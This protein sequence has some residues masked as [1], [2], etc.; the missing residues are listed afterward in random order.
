MDREVR[1]RVAESEAAALRAPEVSDR[2][3]HQLVS[4][5]KSV[6]STLAAKTSED[7]QQRLALIQ[8]AEDAGPGPQSGDLRKRA[9]SLYQDFLKWRTGALRF[10]AGVEERLAEASW[11]RRLTGSYV[12]TA[13]L[14]ERNR[15]LERVNVLTAAIKAHRDG[16]SDVD[17]DDIDEGDQALWA[18]L[19]G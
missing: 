4:M 16:M 6:E 10:R 2:W 9:A 1:G 14:E 8:A 12:P 13:L 7:K 17:P 19:P 11:R 3:Y 18:V 5:K 15:L